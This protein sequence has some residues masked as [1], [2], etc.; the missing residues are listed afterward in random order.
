MTPF[1]KLYLNNWKRIVDELPICHTTSRR[2]QLILKY[3]LIDIVRHREIQQMSLSYKF[4][5]LVFMPL[6]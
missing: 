3:H 6:P 5:R 1:K 4:K 2:A